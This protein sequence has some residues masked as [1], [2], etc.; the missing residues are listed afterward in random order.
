MACRPSPAAQGGRPRGRPAAAVERERGG[1]RAHRLPL[2]QGQ[3][4]DPGSRPEGPAAGKIG[5]VGPSGAGKSTLV[6]LL[7]RLYDLESGH[8]GRWPGHRQ[9]DPGKPARADRHG[10]PGH[11]Q[12]LHRSIRDNLLYGRRQRRGTHGSSAQGS[13][14]RVHPAAQR[15]RGP[16]RLR[17]PCRRTRSEISG[18]QHIAI[19][20]VLLKDAPILILDEATSALD[21][22]IESAIQEALET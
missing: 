1:V 3:R 20:R 7:L 15:R 8:P 2:R 13:R 9:G 10:H 17:R 11:P 6:N 5:L 14:R 19:A 22:E 12:L 16:P 4:R 21:S 18:G